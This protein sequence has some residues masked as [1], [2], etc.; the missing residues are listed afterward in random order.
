MRPGSI[1]NNLVC[2]AQLVEASEKDP[3]MFCGNFDSHYDFDCVAHVCCG[4]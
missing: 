3:V 2:G 1:N 4:L